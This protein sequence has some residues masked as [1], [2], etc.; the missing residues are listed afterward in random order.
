M[1]PRR[2]A[3][4]DPKK[5]SQVIAITVATILEGRCAGRVLSRLA[6]FWVRHLLPRWPYLCLLDATFK[7]VETAAPWKAIRLPA[8]DADE[9]AMC[10]LMAAEVV[11]PLDAPSC[12][13]V[14]ASEASLHHG[15]VV[16][17][18]CS[19]EEVAWLWSRASVRG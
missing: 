9:Q 12:P 19:L 18:D 17:M 11:A 5:F 8:A 13:T 10:S 6:G 2:T 16:Q 15:A 7:L 3:R 14:T 4:T 1:D